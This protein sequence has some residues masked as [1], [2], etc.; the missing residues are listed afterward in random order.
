MTW[1]TWGGPR[2]QGSSPMGEVWG[3]MVSLFSKELVL[4]SAWPPGL[5]L[6]Q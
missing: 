1:P 5:E 2:A 4:L 6:S 3:P